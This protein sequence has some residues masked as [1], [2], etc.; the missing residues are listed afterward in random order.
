M[1]D[2]R[3][4]DK[5]WVVLAELASVLASQ[6]EMVPEEAFFR[7]RLANNIITYYLLDEHSSFEVLTDAE[8]EL[9]KVQMILFGLCD[10]ELA[11]EYLDKM[12]KAVRNELNVEFPL[13]KSSF[14]P[15][16]KKRKN[17]ESIRIKLNKELQTEILGDL[18]EWYGVIF[19]FSNEL[20]DTVV[21]EGNKDKI[22][23]AL[24]DFSIIW[25]Y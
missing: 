10:D 12:A 23:N 25:K 18:S 22:K 9:S 15:E 3:G 20:D 2:A 19:E 4:I 21:I 7:L 5:Q 8:K 11:K 6:G 16:V 17:I 24:K 13:K 1:K 14:S